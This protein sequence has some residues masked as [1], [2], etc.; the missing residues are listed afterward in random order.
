M[1]DANS[2]G[3][4]GIKHSVTPLAQHEKNPCTA[5]STCLTEVAAV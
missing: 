2:E 1:I 5:A 3:K 4:V